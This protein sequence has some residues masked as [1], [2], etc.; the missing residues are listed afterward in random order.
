MSERTAPAAAGGTAAGRRRQAVMADVAAIAGV[1]QMTV[2]RVLNDRPGVGE[3]TRERVLAAMR[4]VDY[5]PNVAARTLVTGRSRTLGVVTFDSTLYGPA[6]TLYGIELAARHAGYYVTVSTLPA[7]DDR[8]VVEAVDRLREQVI[9]GVVAIAPN[10]GSTTAVRDALTHELPFVAI[11]G[12]DERELCV[13]S[14]DQTTGARRATRHL[15]SLGHETVWHIAGP[16]DW[17]VSGER[18]AAWRAVLEEE[19]REVPEPLV[20][21]WSARSGYQ[22]GTELATRDDV[23]AVFAGNDQMALGVLRAF[24]E[25]GRPAPRHVSVVGFDDLP[26][27]GYF[28]P[29]LTTVRQNFGDVGRRS[30]QLLLAQLES[31]R[32]TPGRTLV[33]P[34]LV[35][36][37]S[38]GRRPG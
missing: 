38:T 36:R 28:I 9:D 31:G 11:E 22:H 34:E 5:R 12:G 15:L 19:G 18:T 32:P 30:L 3:T 1:S 7:F 8:A 33:E 4:E 6:S 24:S 29:P 17:R 14:I 21:D 16:G 2:S 26:E 20:G 27:S 23:T 25:A 35:L 37:E 10:D 13:V